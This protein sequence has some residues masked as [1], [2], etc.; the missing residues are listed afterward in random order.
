VS[1]ERRRAQGGAWR[2]TARVKHLGRTVAAQTFGR[3]V[4]AEAWE[5]EQYRAIQFGEFLPPEQSKKTFSQIVDAFLESRRG[6]VVPH[7]WRT[8][9]DN[10]ANTP[11][12][13]DALPIASITEADILHHLTRE[14]QTKAHSTVSRART[15]LSALFQFAVRE[16]MRARNPVRNVPMPAGTQE[17]DQPNEANAFTDAELIETLDLQRARNPRMAEI[18]EFLSLTGLRWSE[19]RA[20]RIK[21]LQDV[22][23]PAL[24]VSR[25]HSD[26][27]AEKG[28]KTR[29]SRRVPLTARAYEIARERA[30][31]RPASDYLFVSKTGRQL[32]GN[33]FR[34]YSNWTETSFGHTIHDLRH[35]AASSWLRAGIPVHQ[36]A[37]WLGHRNP[38]T[39]LRVYAHVLGENQEIAALKHLDSLRSV[40]AEYTRTAADANLEAALRE[41]GSA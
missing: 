13:W 5:R 20:S 36:V 10:L 12:S 9:R 4:D 34:R 39:T 21:H 40:H 7:T 19:L 15:T 41:E 31:G 25:A 14:L 11:E 16:R 24:R 2:Y 22:P 33:L 32:S 17:D 18:T 27:Y 38:T 30:G 29:N 23:Y 28:T 37:K 8:D 35:Y 26:G 6:Q 1:I 3:K